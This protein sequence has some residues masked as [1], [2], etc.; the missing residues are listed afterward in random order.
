MFEKRTAIFDPMDGKAPYRLGVLLVLF[1]ATGDIF[2][3]ERNAPPGEMTSW[4]LPQGG[5][6][7]FLQR[8]RVTGQESQIQAAMREL[9]EEAGADV[10]AA[11]I[12]MAS[13]PCR[14]DF[15]PGGNDKYRGQILTPVLMR[16]QG[17]KIDISRPE[18]GE[19]QPAFKNYNWF[20][21]NDFLN[22]SAPYKQPLYRQALASFSQII[23]RI[24][25]FLPAS[26]LG[27][28]RGNSYEPL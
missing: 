3:G 27:S 2:A 8:G 17:G 5:I 28:K 1:N 9:R 19:S 23:G 15:A 24:T 26:F 10:K 21:P 22:L 13:K 11:V 12:A 7:Q 16:Y 4:Q 6:Q 20:E 18:D 14:L 25:P